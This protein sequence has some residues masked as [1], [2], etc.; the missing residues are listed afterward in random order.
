MYQALSRTVVIA[1]LATG[2][3]ACDSGSDA[4]GKKRRA[5]EHL[6]HVQVV[7]PQTYTYATEHTGS[8][9]AGRSTRL[10][11]Q[12]EGRLDRID[13]WEGDRVKKGQV[14]ARLDDSL[15]RA[16][17]GKLA[18]ERRQARYN[19]KRLEGLIGGN[20][21]SKEQLE[22]ARTELAVAEAEE[23]VQKTRVG[24]TRIIAPYDGVV[25]QRLVEQGD[26][27]A[28]HT[29]VLSVY[30]PASLIT[31]LTVSE[32]LLTSLHNGDAVD[33]RIDALGT[34][35]FSGQV[36]RIHPTVDERT[37]RGLVEVTLKPVP[38]GATAGQLCRVTL[39]TRRDNRI[40]V[41]FAALQRDME[42]EY[43]F[44]ADA[45]NKARRVPVRTGLRFGDSVEVQ[46]GLEGG[47][48]VIVRGFFGLSVGKTVKIVEREPQGAD[49][50]GKGKDPEPESEQ[51]AD[52]EPLAA[53]GRG[54]ASG[55]SK[56]P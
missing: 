16:E 40:L 9:R 24:Y 12:E 14:L 23:N 29:H 15:L 7:K 6:V 26:V 31:E 8:L 33:V 54:P 21:A 1:L 46:G 51:A 5:G 47:A 27:V 17:L 55:G 19:V 52:G 53:E 18:A 37:R 48:R 4:G 36:T 32:L 10:F 30:D 35:R 44:V 28:R 34:E 56:T 45:D 50:R 25:S 38:A 13:V 39:K 42:S 49:A 11:S 43:V 20:L 3:V 2:L 41:P 22:K